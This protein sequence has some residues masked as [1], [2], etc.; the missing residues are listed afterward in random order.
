MKKNVRPTPPLTRGK[1]LLFA[2][3]TLL[4][5]VL[6]FI[7]LELGLRAGGYGPDLSLFVA[8]TISGE[9]LYRIN[10]GVKDRYFSHFPFTPT[11]SVDYFAVPKPAGAYR[12]FCLGGSTTAGYPYWFNGSFSSF[13]R[14]RLRAVF[15][16]KKIEIINCGITATNSYTVN[17]MAAELV[18][19]EPDLLIVYDGHN[20]FYGALGGASH[21]SVGRFRGLTKMYLSFIHL[22]TFLLM[23]EAAGGVAGL[24]RSSSAQ[25]SPGTMMERLARG[26]YIPYGSQTYM[27]TL[28]DYEDNLAD[29]KEICMANGVRLLLSSQVSNLRDQPPFISENSDVPRTDAQLDA[30][31]WRDSGMQEWQNGRVDSAFEHFRRSVRSDSLR[32]DSHFMLGRCFEKMGQRDEAGREYVKARDNDQLRFRASSDFNDALRSACDDANAIYVDMEHIFRDNS[33]DSLIGKSLMVE[34]LHPNARGFFLM[35]AALATAMRTH[36]L[37]A[38][39]EEWRQ[40]DTVAAENLWER[41]CLTDI[42]EMIAKRRTEILTA[43]WPFKDQTPVV[44]RVDERDTLGLIVEDVTRG[45]T[46]WLQAHQDACEYYAARRDT[47]RLAREYRVLINQVPHDVKPYLQ[48]AHILLRQGNISEVRQLLL[49]TLD[50]SKTILAYRALGDIAMNEG[51]PGEAVAFYEGTLQFKQSPREQ[52]ENGYLLAL[53]LSRSGRNAEAKAQVLKILKINPAYKQGVELLARIGQ[54][55]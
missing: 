47:A 28:R 25:T 53:A 2:A 12:I 19:Y 36:G 1:R 11:T 50:L 55:D 35:G 33:P 42:D 22:K 41:R 6:F 51:K 13:L 31:R 39:V 8:D 14:D 38:S 46:D 7:L 24:F 37:L 44:D 5:P 32:A 40:H 17:D 21:E 16:E 45:R 10:P 30:K 3:F 49:R 15:P 52:V 9:T 18:D 43:G 20:E 54:S 26:Q 34:H 23:K 48:L 4:I 29:L 27:R